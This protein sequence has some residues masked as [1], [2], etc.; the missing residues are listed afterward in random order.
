MGLRTLRKAL[1]L[2]CWVCCPLP[3]LALEP[4]PGAGSSTV[5]IPF[6]TA[7]GPLRAGKLCLPNGKVRVRD[8]VASQSAFA[9]MVTDAADS[10]PADRNARPS[11]KSPP[12]AVR[13]VGITAKLC[14]K[15]WGAFSFGDRRSLSG[16][17]AFT[18]EVGSGGVGADSAVTHQIVLKLKGSQALPPADILN[19]A[20][21]QLLAEIVRPGT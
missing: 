5:D 14:A 4:S 11:T 2:L 19:A 20:L 3:A 18:F 10:R 21:I 8:F 13:L 16:D 17:A 7:V 9:A 1:P 12:V 15:D 6:A